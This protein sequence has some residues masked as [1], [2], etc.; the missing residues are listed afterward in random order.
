MTC[1]NVKYGDHGE[2]QAPSVREERY[3]KVL[4]RERERATNESKQSQKRT[5]GKEQDDRLLDKCGSG[6]CLFDLIEQLELL[7]AVGRVGH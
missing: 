2:A 6:K 1:E 3:M 5:E 7:L 4:W